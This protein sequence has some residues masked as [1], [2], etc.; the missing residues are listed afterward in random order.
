MN[1]IVEKDMCCQEWE[2]LYEL[3]QAGIGGGVV[4]KKGTDEIVIR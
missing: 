3:Q 4:R 1:I 2:M